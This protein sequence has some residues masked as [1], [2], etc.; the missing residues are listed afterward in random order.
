M[1]SVISG[2]QYDIFIS[3]RHNDNRSGWV[4][5]FVNAL[6]EELAAT[7]K[8]PLSIYFDKN[9]HD[10]LLETHNVDK[11]LEGKLKCLIFIPIISQTYCDPKSFAW[12]HEFVVFNKLAK[13]DQF[14]RDIRQSNGNVTNRILPIKI[15][16]LDAEDKL[17]IE[18]EIGGVLRAIE[19]SFKSSGVNRPLTSTDKREENSG[20]T[21]YK[22]QVNKVANAI[23]EIISAIKSPPPIMAQS[24][25]VHHPAPAFQKKSNRK[26]IVIASFLLLLATAVVF[27]YQQRSTNNQQLIL[28]KSIAVLPF[29][30]MS[31]AHDQEYFG[32]GVAEE[33]I[34]VLVQIPD[35]KVI[36]RT[37]S[38]QFKGKNEDLKRI[39]ELLGVSNI[40][41]GS[42]RK[43]ADQLRITAQLIN[44]KDGS[45]L[46]S[47]TFDRSP[48]DV[49]LLQDEIAREV[50]RAF[51]LTLAGNARSAARITSNEAAYTAYL[52]GLYF[53]DQGT[54]D[55]N[56]KA[57]ELFTKSIQLDSNFAPAWVELAA[58][59]WRLCV[60]RVNCPDL[61][62]IKRLAKRGLELDPDNATGHSTMSIFYRGEFKMK[63]SY[64]ESLK[65]FQLDPRNPRVLRIHGLALL[66]MN[67][68][69]EA[70]EISKKSIS[71]DPVQPNSYRY[72]G[73]A[74]YYSGRFQEA[75]EVYKKAFELSPQLLASVVST[76]YALMI[77]MAKGADALLD[78]LK[79]EESEQ[80]KLAGSAIAYYLKGDLTA[81]NESL[82]KLISK[83]AG[84]N[85]FEIA[86]V[87]AF[88]KDYLKTIEWLNSSYHQKN[89]GL[90]LVGQDPVFKSF[91]G[92]PKFEEIVAKL[93][94]P[95]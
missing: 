63:E 35:L 13:E 10:G 11:S 20:K 17:T 72:L 77:L 47:K 23:K 48:K 53:F 52:Q 86:Q 94:I 81:S 16:D 43:S 65:A 64:E 93:N 37:S 15:H 84:E 7:I 80:T 57:T 61:P 60:G 44:V 24:S 55:G 21:I 26:K 88:R 9:P 91:W 25:S 82:N 75:F 36:A 56:Q 40:L 66:T 83:Y 78:F 46:W 49:L 1:A 73:R 54:L 70:I 58:N 18:N 34:N 68:V 59:K 5:E 89:Y 14:G 62:E 32:D 50:A 27:F 85:A 29:V 42:V 87:Y 45:H 38:F 90:I 31:P 79:T 95:N 71:L 28:D 3:Y 30:D 19:F 22:D 76:E 33:I 6:Q 12:Q 41:E 4:T 69:D 2:Y 67:R 92:T 39:G 8:E 51:K 74:Y